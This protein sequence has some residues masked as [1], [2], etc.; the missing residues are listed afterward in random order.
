MAFYAQLN[1]ICSN[2]V[3]NASESAASYFHDGHDNYLILHSDGF[4]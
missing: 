1:L 2:S 3:T 4:I